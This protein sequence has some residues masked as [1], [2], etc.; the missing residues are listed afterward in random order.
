MSEA[1]RGTKGREREREERKIEITES[2]L[3][4]RE[5]VRDDEKKRER[6]KKMES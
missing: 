4:D 3:R 2:G 6:I 1:G 5:R